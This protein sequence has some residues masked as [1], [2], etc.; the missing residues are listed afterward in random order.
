[1]TGKGMWTLGVRP[2][3]RGLTPVRVDINVLATILNH[4]RGPI[5]TRTCQ[6]ANP[7]IGDESENILEWLAKYKRGGDCR[8]ENIFQLTFWC[9]CWA[10]TLP[11]Y[12]TGCW[13]GGIS[14]THHESSAYCR[15]CQM[16]V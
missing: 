8:T 15:V 6:L 13:W 16:L 1:M 14:V 12:I 4:V 3:I 2:R 9:T 5:L 7:F 11:A 10:A